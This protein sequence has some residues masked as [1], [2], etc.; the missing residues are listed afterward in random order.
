MLSSSASSASVH[1]VDL[2]DELIRSWGSKFK[3]T[4]VSFFMSLTPLGYSDI[5]Q[6]STWTN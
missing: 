1:D 5:A 3:I 2:K 4:V 6:I